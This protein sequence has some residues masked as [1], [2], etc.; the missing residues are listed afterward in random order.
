MHGDAGDRV[1]GRGLA[2]SSKTEKQTRGVRAV[3]GQRARVN[4]SSCDAA[5]ATLDVSPLQQSF[6]DGGRNLRAV[7]RSLQNAKPNLGRSLGGQARS[8]GPP[9]NRSN[10]GAAALLTGSLWSVSHVVLHVTEYRPEL[11]KLE[12]EIVAGRLPLQSMNY[13][14]PPSPSPFRAAPCPFFASMMNLR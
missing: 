10:L 14:R 7:V 1:G 8:A 9:G 12:P 4:E 2:S 11:W 13:S 6:G 5:G 3:E